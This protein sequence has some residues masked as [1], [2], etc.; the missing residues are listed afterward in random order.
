MHV[1]KLEVVTGMMSQELES[2][3]SSSFFTLVLPKP[4]KA[5]RADEASPRFLK[6][7]DK[8]SPEV[9]EGKR[10]ASL[11]ST[12]GGLKDTVQTCLAHPRIHHM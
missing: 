11:A 7:A 5:W 9:Q 4:D 10:R 12:K 1:A 6:L 8:R 3:F 2:K